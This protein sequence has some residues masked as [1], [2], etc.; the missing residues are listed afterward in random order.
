M[1]S[2]LFPEHTKAIVTFT[3]KKHNVDYKIACADCHHDYKDGK[4]VWKDGDEVK[5]CDACHTEAKA[6][7]GDKTPKAGEIDLIMEP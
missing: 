2:K 3:H 7:K 5:R 4:N 1:E 6:P